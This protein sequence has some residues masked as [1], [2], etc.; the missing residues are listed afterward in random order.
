MRHLALEGL[1]LA[2]QRP[3]QGVAEGGRC[4]GLTARWR[5]WLRNLVVAHAYV[6]HATSQKNKQF[7]KELEV[8]L[9]AVN[10]AEGRFNGKQGKPRHIVKQSST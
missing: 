6:R 10:V 2:A 9:K 1:S 8:M 5:R 3:H 4:L 7:V